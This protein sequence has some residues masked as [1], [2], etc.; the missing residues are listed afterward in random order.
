VVG[1]ALGAGVVGVVEMMDD[2]LYSEKEIR[3]LLP[4]AAISEIPAVVNPSDEISARRQMWLG[5][6]SAAIVFA[7]IL[8]GSAFSYL[9]G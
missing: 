9:R 1:L 5:W 4:V 6:V 3:D 7:T 2:R 8:A